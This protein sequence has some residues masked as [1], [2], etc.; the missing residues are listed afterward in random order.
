MIQTSWDAIVIGAGAAGLSAAQALGRSLRRTLVIDAGSPRNRFA[1]HVHNALG[2]DGKSPTELAELGRTEAERYGVEFHAG[3]VA[4][5]DESAGGLRVTLEAT[6]ETVQSFDARV[7]IVATGVRDILPEIAGLARHWGTGVLH[8][9]Y[10]HGW[11][12][13]G[14]RIGVVTSSPLSLHQAKM[15]RQWSDNVTVF[16]AALGELDAATARGFAARGVRVVPSP[17]EEVQGD[18]A[19]V[20]AVVTADKKSHA[21]NAVFVTSALAPIDG[22]LAGLNLAREDQPWGSFIGVDQTGQTSHP[23]IFAAGNVVQPMATIP[24]AMGTGTIAGAAANYA[25]VEED[26][27]LAAANAGHS[28]EG[29]PEYDPGHVHGSSHNHGSAHAQQD[30]HED[31]TLF[32]ERRYSDS[33]RIWSGRVNEALAA[34]SA[35][36]VPGRSL[37]LGCGEGGDVLWLAERGWAATGIDLSAT[38]VSRAV[39]E[40]ASREL[41][42]ARFVAGDLGDWVA[43]GALIDGSAQ[44]FD[45]I[46]ASFMQSPVE[47]PRQ[48]ILRAALTRLA[49]GGRLV[50]LTHAAPPPWAKNHPGEFLP[51]EGEVALLGLEGAPGQWVIEVA[52]VRE[53]DAEGP[54]G[55][56]HHLEDTVV[57]VRR[58]A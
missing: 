56:Q 21:V 22:F 11:E 49:P 51:P 48:R 46:T 1:G 28:H 50:V 12:V 33:D 25:L 19:Q 20:T 26:Y 6:G 2:L 8:C 27:A 13:R 10:C 16:S 14:S 41:T 43:R 30:P 55:R 9:P 17:V 34:V 53:R 58:V 45:L 32:W 38:A 7:L 37:D 36:W 57:V 18:G 54:D 15:L 35:D 44:P 3:S 23:R 52:E 4:S 42:E 31:P 39:T 29:A 24:S 5:V 40:A 47:L